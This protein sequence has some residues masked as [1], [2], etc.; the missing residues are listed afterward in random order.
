MYYKNAK[1]KISHVE[2]NNISGASGSDDITL[3]WILCIF[4]YYCALK[5]FRC[6][7]WSA[8]ISVLFKGVFLIYR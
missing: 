2:K 1:A 6:L 7:P 8:Y 4:I 3:V 5:S